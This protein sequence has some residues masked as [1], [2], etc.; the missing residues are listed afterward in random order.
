MKAKRG[1]HRG[2][3]SGC[4]L[5]EMTQDAAIEATPMP[6]AMQVP[7]PADPLSCP[8]MSPEEAS[9]LT[10]K[11]EEVDAKLTDVLDRYGAAI[12]TGVLSE[13]ECQEYE[14]LFTEDL[15]ELVDMDEVQSSSAEV[16]AAAAAALKD[17]H[18]WPTASVPLLGMKERCQHRGLPHGRFA[19][20]G[21]LNRNVRHCY[22]I[23]HGTTALVS[24]CDNSF[25]AP[26]GTP[27]KATNDNWPHV[28]HNKHD[29]RFWDDAEPC[30]SVSEW[31]V[32]QGILYVWE[33]TSSNSSTTVL[34][35]GS[36]R[37][38]YEEMMTDKQLAKRGKKG[39]HFSMISFTEQELKESLNQRWRKMARRVPM[40]A[41]SLLLWSSKLVH[42]GWSGGPRL[43]QPVC[44]EPTSRRGPLARDRKLRMA[45]LGLPSTHWASL[46]IPHTLVDIKPSQ[47]TKARPSHK[48]VE[49]PLKWSLKLPSLMPG[50]D[51]PDMWRH[52]QNSDFEKTVLEDMKEIVDLEKMLRPEIVNAL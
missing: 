15:S 2:A 42:Q 3:S 13:E 45:A 8:Q 31:E 38:V 24:S 52:F 34:W 6:A 22:E 50:V 21:R 5:G 30:T 9:A 43:A 51:V 33:S 39:N 26:V 17:V 48:G 32:Y 47:A 41:G 16:Q 1:R 7:G 49:L 28:D 37:D 29:N 4:Q 23:I 10:V 18:Q 12:V 11:M 44:W 36:H 20:A 14:K 19:W 46:G 35:T 25:F 27:E 40:P